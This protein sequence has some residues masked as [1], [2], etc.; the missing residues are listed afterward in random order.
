MSAGARHSLHVQIA[1]AG[2]RPAAGARHLMDGAR[3]AD[4]QAHSS[5]DFA[6]GGRG[7][8]VQMSQS[9]NKVRVVRPPK[10]FPLFSGRNSLSLSLSLARSLFASPFFSINSLAPDTQTQSKPPNA[11]DKRRQLA[12]KLGL[13]PPTRVACSGRNQAGRPVSSVRLTDSRQ[14]FDRF[15]SLSLS[16]SPARSLAPLGLVQPT[17]ALRLA[18]QLPGDARG[19]PK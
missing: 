5:N 10:C 16:L 15:R 8:G 19:A 18:G 6:L 1:R 12:P 3:A 17:F 11:P 14:C 2:R 4:L 9:A 7:G 13:Q